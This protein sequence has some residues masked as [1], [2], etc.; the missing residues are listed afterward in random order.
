MYPPQKTPIYVAPHK[1]NTLVIVVCM[2]ITFF[3]G[4]G[5]MKV[6]SSPETRNQIIEVFNSGA[7]SVQTFVNE[8][9]ANQ[10]FFGDQDF[11]PN[12][13]L[14]GPADFENPDSIAAVETTPCQ[15]ASEANRAQFRWVIFRQPY[16][17]SCGNWRERRVAKRIR[18]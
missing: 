2:M 16:Q 15:I 6:Y 13:D 5:I 3:G 9:L 12:L 18:L 4:M 1:S 7:A 11:D 10:T 17:D 8:T 14:E